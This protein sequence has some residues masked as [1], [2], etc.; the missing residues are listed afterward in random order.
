MKRIFKNNVLFFS[1][2]F[3][4]FGFLLIIYLIINGNTNQ[5]FQDIVLEC[6][7]TFS[8]NKTIECDLIYLFSFGGIIVYSIYY[9]LFRRK[10]SNGWGEKTTDIGGKNEN[11]K[12]FLCAI[13]T[14]AFCYYCIYGMIQNILIAAVILLVIIFIFDRSILLEGIC[15][16]FF[17]IYSILAIYRFYIELGGMKNIN[18]MF[19]I[20][21]S[22]LFTLMLVVGK[23]RMHRIRKASL[24]V[25]TVIPMILLIFLSSNYYVQDKITVLEV[26][27]TVKIL[28][29][30]LIIL[31]IA[32]TIYRLVTKW[33]KKNSFSESISLGVCISIMTFNRYSGNGVIMSTDMH[34][35]FENI[36]GYSQIFELGQKPF[37][38]YIPV[39][40][41]YSVIEGFIFDVF[42]NGEFAYYNVSQNIFYLFIIMLVLILLR[43]Q[44]D[45]VGVF[46]I[47]LFFDIPDYNRIV[48][49]IPI[50]LLLLMPKLIENKN[51]WLKVWMLTSLF[52]GLY[53]P[54][55]G[56]AVCLAFLPLGMWQFITFIRSNEFKLSVRKISFWVE[57]CICIILVIISAPY[58]LGTYRHI[59]AM[60]SQSVLA[61]GLSRFGQ[62]IPNEFFPYLI[63]YE[64]VRRTFYYLFS[65]MIPIVFV[66]IACAIALKLADIKFENNKLVY[67]NW[68]EFSLVLSVAIML[69]VSYTYT[70]VRLDVGSIYARNRFVLAIASIILIVV[71]YKHIKEEGLKFL[72][73]SIAFFVPA[74]SNMIGMFNNDGKLSAYYKVQEDYVYVEDDTISKI[75]VGYMQQDIYN[76]VKE[77]MLLASKFDDETSFLGI[78]S[79]FGYY[80]LCETKGDSVMEITPTI[81]CYEA[82]KETIEIIKNNKS[83]V[84]KNIDT[85]RNYYLYNWLL[86][87]G[88]YIWSSD[89][90][91]FIP[92]KDNIKF[93][94]VLE[95]NNHATLAPEAYVLG[96]NPGVLGASK[97]SLNNVF[98]KI[99][100]EMDIINNGLGRYIHSDE[101]FNGNTFD[102]IYIEFANLEN[103]YQ[104]TLYDHGGEY[105]QNVEENTLAKYLMKKSY[106][107]DLQIII[108]WFDEMGMGHNMY[109]NMHQGK[110]LIPLGAGAKWLLNNHNDIF[111]SVFKNGVE[112]QTPEIIEV[113][114]LKLRHIK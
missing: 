21:T 85:L 35:P 103:N 99:E 69:L 47:A 10:Y 52:H 49:I 59:K 38:E 9:I 94:E 108:T 109:C 106:N 60:A 92:N 80:Y 65:F 78:F 15:F 91:C 100:L 55:F 82:A 37:V 28:I 57:W 107:T 84:G 17:S 1:F 51:M 4:L 54:V 112:I 62:L 96:N 3:I 68:K 33:N 76:Q 56:A 77:A 83:I 12:V 71:A 14:V 19:I 105:I 8:S 29:I 75:G 88:E 22:L 111:I 90:E 25:Q 40:G 97:N 86:T 18:M 104:Y 46:L 26:P 39:S 6:T 73:I 72:I 66:W 74:S 81:K 32:E 95:I 63:E 41:L 7:A 67:V 5:I 70:F 79:T 93:E 11:Q 61:D 36:I 64:F 110:L 44:I 50:M 13:G 101:V 45:G 20:I 43:T 114:C 98:T 16:Y 58:L 89:L 102:Y 42:G 31:F 2:L 113:E 53:Y 23:N 30:G 48:F 27:I 87:S 34:H 24:I